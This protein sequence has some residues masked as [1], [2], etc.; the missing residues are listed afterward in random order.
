MIHMIILD[1]KRKTIFCYMP[2]QFYYI[3]QFSKFFAMFLNVK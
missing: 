1:A 2:G 3:L